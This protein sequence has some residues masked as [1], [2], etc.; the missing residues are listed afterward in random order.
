MEVPL[1]V[2]A[3]VAVVADV[4]VSGEVVPVS[5]VVRGTLLAGSALSSVSVHSRE[6]ESNRA[7]VPCQHWSE[8]LDH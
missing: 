7:I 6:Y 3:E 2:A 1:C 4:E 8:L 5:D